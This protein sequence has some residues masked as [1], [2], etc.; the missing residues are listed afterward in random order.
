[1]SFDKN[2]TSPN[3]AHLAAHPVYSAI[4]TVD[5]LK[6]F[7]GHHVFPVWDF[8][9]LIKYL[10]GKLAPTTFPWAPAGDPSVVRFI[11][12]LVM[13]EESDQNLPGGANNGGPEFL[14]HFALY[15]GAMKEIGADPSGAVEFTGIAASKGIRAAIDSGLAPQPAAEFMEKTFSFINTDKPH[16]VAAAFALGREHVIPEMFRSFLAKMNISKN[17][18]PAFH[19]YLERHIHLDSD[20]HAPMSIRMVDILC[21]GDK[22]KIAEASEAAIA[23]IDARISFWDGVHANILAGKIS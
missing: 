2:F 1:M 17:D 21:D 16:V 19:Y 11:N 12:E 10:Q 6:I 3:Q 20:F 23:A 4:K 13:E 18:A 5:D 9:S 14:S 22:N 8:M 15:M 7:M